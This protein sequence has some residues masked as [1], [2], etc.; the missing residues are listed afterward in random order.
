[1]KENHVN[2]TVQHCH[3]RKRK[4]M[5]KSHPTNAT[6]TVRIQFLTEAMVFLSRQ[7]LAQETFHPVGFHS[8]PVNWAQATLCTAKQIFVKTL[9]LPS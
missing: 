6:I 3:K 2:E 1:M 4:G 5:L 9:G 8:L 7:A